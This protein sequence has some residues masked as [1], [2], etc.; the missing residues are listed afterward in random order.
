MVQLKAG[1]ATAD[2]KGMTNFNSTMVQLKA[3]KAYSLF[4][5]VILF[6]F[7]YGSIKRVGIAYNWN[8]RKEISIP[9]WFD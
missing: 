9:L 7:H 3:V 4:I 2:R 6:Q 1:K 5:E 8:T